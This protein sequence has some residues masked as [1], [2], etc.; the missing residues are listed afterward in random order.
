MK[1][2]NDRQH[3]TLYDTTSGGTGQ[4][5][6]LQELDSRKQEHTTLQHQDYGVSDEF[7]EKPEHGRKFKQNLLAQEAGT[8][9][10]VDE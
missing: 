9:E 3:R 7:L 4:R 6:Y 8:D 5:D 1:N 2:G 10:N